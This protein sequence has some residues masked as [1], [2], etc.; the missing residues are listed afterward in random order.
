MGKQ[1][2]LDKIAVVS[3][4]G[5]RIGKA[6]ASVSAAEGARV[7]IVHNAASFLGAPVDD[8]PEDDLK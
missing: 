1:R 6:I 3:G 8:Y 4:A 2:L 7:V 5:Q